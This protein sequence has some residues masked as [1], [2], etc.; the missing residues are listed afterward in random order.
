VADLSDEILMAHADGELEPEERARVDRILVADP[1]ARAQWAKFQA[2]GKTLADLFP[3]RL[4]EPVPQHL[5]DLV[6]AS[7]GTSRLPIGAHGGRRG[8]LRVRTAAANLFVPE[9]MLMWGPALAYSTVLLVGACAGWLLH[10]MHARPEAAPTIV[11][12]R[13]G[14]ILAQGALQRALEAAASGVQVE[15]TSVLEEPAA[16]RIRLSFWSK[17]QAFCRQYDLAL[18]SE[19]SRFSGVA[20]RGNDEHWQVQ[21]HL[22]VERHQPVGGKVAPAGL[23][24]PVAAF[25]DRMS[26]NDAL[27]GPR[28]AAAIR[29]RWRAELAPN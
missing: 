19:P 2:T 26:A 14:R 27:D 29:N 17:H 1:V 25:V 8:W 21:V 4:D 28:E 5:V 22:P 10:S 18:G 12:Q 15:S 20:C 23:D 7:N 13:D 9:R 16:V 11:V 24:N 6:L 3:A